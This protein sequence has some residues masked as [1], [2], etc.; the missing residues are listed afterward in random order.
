MASPQFSA[1]FDGLVFRQSTVTEQDLIAEAERIAAIEQPNWNFRV[2]GDIGWFAVRLAIKAL[3]Q[4]LERSNAWGNEFNIITARELS[5]IIA[6][7]AMMG[8][9][10][11]SAHPS[12]VNVVVTM[13]APYTARSFDQYALQLST[14]NVMGPANE[15]F[16]ENESSLSVGSGV[17]QLV[18]AMVS[19]QSFSQDYTANDEAFQHFVLINN[20]ALD[21]SIRVE[22]SSVDWEFVADL[23]DSQPGDLH[24]TTK[25][26]PDGSTDVQFGDGIRGAIPPNGVTG[27]ARYRV[28]G[29]KLA[30]VPKETITTVI[31]TPFAGLIAINPLEA[32]GGFDADT[33]DVIVRNAL[34]TVKMGGGILGNTQM[35]AAYCEDF[36]GVARAIASLAGPQMLVSAIPEGG[37]ALPATLKTALRNALD[38][39]LPQGQSS[40]VND[41]LYTRPG[42]AVDF[43]TKDGFV[44]AQVEAGVRADIAA[45]MNPLSQ[46][47]NPKTRRIE[48]RRQ[49]GQK[50]FVNDIR[51]VVSARPDVEKDFVVSLPAHDVDVAVLSIT[52]DAGALIVARSRNT[53]T[54]GSAT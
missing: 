7:A 51:A 43:T 10:P 15:V 11:K 39:L 24:F 32:G 38:A 30:N 31:V 33:A 17:Q 4:G 40:S 49:F 44:S 29:G 53:T 52:T 23:V 45:L 12:R 42:V 1:Q 21:G 28:G 34:D 6:R 8:Y 41:V 20:G 47:V 54:V 2:E 13:P 5:S 14:K 25:L 19:G 48:Y 18:V 35:V 3:V 9:T 50:L 46:V 37:G 16:F 26:L 22:F 27:T 36:P